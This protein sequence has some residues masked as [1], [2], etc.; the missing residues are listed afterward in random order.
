MVLGPGTQQEGDYSTR[1]WAKL[2][3]PFQII[4]ER[5]KSTSA[6]NIEMR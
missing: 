2:V 4:A 5:E 3:G 6:G 1:R